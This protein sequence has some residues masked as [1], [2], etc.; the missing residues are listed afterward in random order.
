MVNVEDNII[1]IWIRRF[2]QMSVSKL[3]SVGA[4]GLYFFPQRGLQ[5]KNDFR[6]NTKIL[7]AFLVV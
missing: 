6:N 5:D 1:I 3:C 7:L 2:Y 4:Q